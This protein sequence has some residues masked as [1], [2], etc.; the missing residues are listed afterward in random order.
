[1]KRAK[2]GKSSGREAL[3]S[4]TEYSPFFHDEEQKIRLAALDHRQKDI[5]N[6]RKK[7]QKAT[8][9]IGK[10]K[11]SEEKIVKRNISYAL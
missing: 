5:M 1:M 8:I 2:I 11:V 9:A 4:G 6:Y 3:F 7:G 10:I